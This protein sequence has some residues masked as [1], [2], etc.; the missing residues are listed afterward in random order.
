MRRNVA[1]MWLST[2]KGR[3]VEVRESDERGMAGDCYREGGIDF[4]KIRATLWPWLAFKSCFV[5]LGQV[6]MTEDDEVKWLRVGDEHLEGF[7]CERG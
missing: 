2:P 5:G 7:E 6:L 1:W 3:D 4:T